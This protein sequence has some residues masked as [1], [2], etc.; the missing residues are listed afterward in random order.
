MSIEIVNNSGEPWIVTRYV[1]GSKNIADTTEVNHGDKV[2][3]DFYDP[4]RG[5]LSLRPARN[6]HERRDY[7]AT[8]RDDDS[9]RELPR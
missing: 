3:L 5:H 6:P 7:R 8:V 1:N 4:E 9:Y 2:V